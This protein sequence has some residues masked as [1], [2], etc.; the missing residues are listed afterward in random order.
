MDRSAIYES[1]FREIGYVPD[2]PKELLQVERAV[3]VRSKQQDEIME[4]LSTIRSRMLP[5]RVGAHWRKHRDGFAEIGV[6]TQ[7]AYIEMV[8]A[9]K[10]RKDL[11]VFTYIT[12]K[13]TQYRLWILV[14]VDNGIVAMYNESQGTSWSF[15][16]Q[17][18]VLGYIEGGRRWWVEVTDFGGEIIVSLLR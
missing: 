2:S 13:P 9:H 5:P 15:F 16:R 4:T 10:K 14:G 6:R 3:E 12:T 7:I 8:E 11:R 1:I 18:D 17:G